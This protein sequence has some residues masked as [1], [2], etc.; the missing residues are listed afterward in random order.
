[1]S[2]IDLSPKCPGSAFIAVRSHPFILPFS[3]HCFRFALFP[4]FLSDL[5]MA[6]CLL[7]LPQLPNISLSVRIVNAS[8]PF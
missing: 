6:L 1:L 8:S 2:L 4:G 3:P 5:R 7:F